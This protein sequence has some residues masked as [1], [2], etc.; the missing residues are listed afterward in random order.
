MSEYTEYLE[1]GVR[2]IEPESKDYLKKLIEI[3]KSFGSSGI[4]VGKKCLNLQ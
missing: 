2:E 4:T 1:L 3:T